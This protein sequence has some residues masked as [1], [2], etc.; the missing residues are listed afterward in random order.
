MKKDEKIYYNLVS[1][2]SRNP[3]YLDGTD[4][5]YAMDVEASTNAS[6]KHWA[7][8]DVC[9]KTETGFELPPYPTISYLSGNEEYFG[10]YVT[11]DELEELRDCERWV[12]RDPD[13]FQGVRIK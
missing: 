2:P 12:G 5:R 11:E 9:L 10:S 4:N 6:E 8:W 13:K 3:H 7:F 1:N